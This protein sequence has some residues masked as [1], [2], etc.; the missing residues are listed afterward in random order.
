[1]SSKEVNSMPIATW[2]IFAVSIV[3]G[4]RD[5]LRSSTPR[6]IRDRLD[7]YESLARSTIGLRARTKWADDFERYIE[8]TPGVRRAA[9]RYMAPQFKKATKDLMKLTFEVK[10]L[11]KKMKQLLKVK[12]SRKKSK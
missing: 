3:S 5:N 4:V 8:A 12:E 11:S 2:R 7:E 10:D 9:D 1:M 6:P